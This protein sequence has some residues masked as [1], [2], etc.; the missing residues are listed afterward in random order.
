MRMRSLTAVIFLLICV[1]VFSYKAFGETVCTI[2]G[3][4]EITGVYNFGDNDF[5]AVCINDEN[6][7]YCVT[8]GE[9]VV[10]YDTGISANTNVVS[11]NGGCLYF[12][13][14]TLSGGTPAVKVCRLDC[15]SNTRSYSV[16][17]TDIH[18]LWDK[19]AADRSGNFYF[20]ENDDV[21]IVR[22]N[23]PEERINIDGVPKALIPSCFDDRVYCVTQRGLCVIEGGDVFELPV[24]SEYV[25]TSADGFSDNHGNVYSL[26]GDLLC[27][28]F[29]GVHGSVSSNGAFFGIKGGRLVQIYN[30]KETAVCDMDESA[31]LCMGSGRFVS[32]SQNGD[33]AEFR[34]FD[35]R[36]IYAAS[37]SS[38]PTTDSED[39]SASFSLE[40]FCVKGDFLCG[41]PP[42]TTAARIKQLL[43]PK[44]CSVRFFD[45]NNNEKKSGAVGTGYK[46]LISDENDSEYTIVVYGDLS[47][48]GS[49]NTMDRR[50]LMNH[51]LK[52]ESLTGA[53]SEAADM[54][55]DG[56][57]DLKDLVMLNF[58]LNGEG[59]ISQN[60]NK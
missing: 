38:S 10:L 33:T 6:Y 20:I 15:G 4:G 41:I 8:E 31:F 54:N 7:C 45:S 28:G 59:S 49:V 56:K 40:N 39:K 51:F 35:N 58:S 9:S 36:P 44:N 2:D 55:H 47:G 5:A 11:Y 26:G 18:V 42:E 25:Y 30:E 24:R 27:G 34:F 46:V 13:E 52:N 53:V 32:V 17:N 37:S 50:K 14:N 23:V 16:I 1:T 29:T 12:F 48:E 60:P 22:N 3:C 21:Q 43:D 57:T 19:C